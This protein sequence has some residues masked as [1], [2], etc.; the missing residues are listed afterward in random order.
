[1]DTVISFALQTNG[2]ECKPAAAA[3][4]TAPSSS[5]SQR[6][7]NV[8]SVQ[9]LHS[10]RLIGL[11]HF[12]YSVSTSAGLQ[13]LEAKLQRKSFSFLFSLF[14]F[15]TFMSKCLLHCDA[16]ACTFAIAFEMA[17]CPALGDFFSVC[18]YACVGNLGTGAQPSQHGGVGLGGGSGGVRV[19]SA[20]TRC[21][22]HRQ[23]TH[24]HKVPSGAD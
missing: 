15:N 12:V 20:R 2:A 7:G 6:C 24:C 5:A 9:R 10:S 8:K 22:F 3:A 13:H 18:D 1:M 16:P 19:G 4:S 21:H 23:C 11:Y 17:S 14:F